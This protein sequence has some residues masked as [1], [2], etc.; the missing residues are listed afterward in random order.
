M[1]AMLLPYCWLN[2]T[3]IKDTI[4]S[5]GQYLST[6]LPS[7]I[8]RIPIVTALRT[9]DQTKPEYNANGI[10]TKGVVCK[11]MLHE[12]VVLVFRGAL[13]SSKTTCCLNC[14]LLENKR[15]THKRIHADRACEHVQ[16]VDRNGV[17]EAHDF[18][19]WPASANWKRRVRV[20][21]H[22]KLHRV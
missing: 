1:T 18:H 11:R 8:Q 9:P 7:E 21:R 12:D 13:L 2:N 17:E 10:C 22:F 4:A 20:V 16:Q 15:R 5:G 14:R 19:D 3:K 6:N